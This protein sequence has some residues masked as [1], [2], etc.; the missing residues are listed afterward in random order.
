MAGSRFMSRIGMTPNSTGII[1]V[2][3]RESV[4]CGPLCAEV[5]SIKSVDLFDGVTCAPPVAVSI[6]T[7][8]IPTAGQK[9]RKGSVKLKAFASIPPPL[10]A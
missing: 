9:R 8:T 5:I 10:R 3:I 7:S 2:F 6:N 4:S 1:F